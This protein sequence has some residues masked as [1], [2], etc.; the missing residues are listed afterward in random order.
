MNI[1]EPLRL[2]VGS[3]SKGSG[4]GCVMNIISWENG[5]KTIS[6]MPDCAAP[7]LARIAQQVNDSICTHRVG[8]PWLVLPGGDTPEDAE[9]PSLLCA[10]CS[11]KVLELGHRTVGTNWEPP[12][13]ITNQAALDECETV[14]ERFKLA[15]QTASDVW[16][17]MNLFGDPDTSDP[18]DYIDG[19]LGR[20]H[21]AFDTFFE[22]SGFKETT[23]P[24]CVIEEA[25]EKMLQPA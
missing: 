8:H 13:F 22:V 2:S 16:S 6:D 19:R 18:D 9:D 5:D 7:V 12:K 3:H 25:Y 24:V 20:A 17:G 4:K 1:T 23:T 11:M 21:K 15:M 10:E 14:G